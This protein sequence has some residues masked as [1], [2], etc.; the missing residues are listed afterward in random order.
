MMMVG[1]KTG[2]LIMLRTVIGKIDH[3]AGPGQ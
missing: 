3:D 1:G 2:K